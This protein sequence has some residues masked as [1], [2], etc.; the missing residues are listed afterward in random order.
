MTQR[1][2]KITP[3][4]RNGQILSVPN[5][6]PSHVIIL[7]LACEGQIWNRPDRVIRISQTLL[8]CLQ[9][10]LFLL[11]RLI[12]VNLDGGGVRVRRRLTI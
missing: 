10:D 6:F 4:L 1:V 2:L 8:I 11:I 9:S 12:N 3:F 7:E 5:P